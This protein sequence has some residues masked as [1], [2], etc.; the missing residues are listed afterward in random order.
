MQHQDK[1][2]ATRKI[3]CCNI[4]KKIMLRVNGA[5]LRSNPRGRPR[6]LLSVPTGILLMPP[7]PGRR[8]RWGSSQWTSSSL[9]KG[10]VTPRD[11]PP[12]RGGAHAKAASRRLA[13]LLCN[14]ALPRV[15]RAFPAF[16]AL[17]LSACTG[18]VDVS[19]TDDIGV[20]LAGAGLAASVGERRGMARPGGATGS[21]LEAGG[22]QLVLLHRRRG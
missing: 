18:L 2:F 5:H 6:P 17:D 3:T 21:V 19:L 14:K 20:E 15:V 8:S 1:R 12:S 11:S 16:V 9:R 10:T 7:A 4:C 13:R 22:H